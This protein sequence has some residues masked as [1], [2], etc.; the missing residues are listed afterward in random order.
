MSGSNDDGA[1]WIRRFHSSPEAEVRLICFPHAGGSASFFFPVS[2]GLAPRAEVLAMQYPGRQ[3]RRSEPNVPDMTQLAN[4]AADSLVPF[5][6]KPYA[7]FGHSMGSTLAYEVARRLQDAGRPAKALFVSGRRAPHR[8]ADDG[9]HL[10]SDEEI[11]ADIGALDGTGAQVFGDA[12]L[13]DM[14]LPAIRS[15]YQAAETYRYAP[16]PILTSPVHALTGFSDAWVDVSEL[17]HWKEHTEA[18][19]DLTVFPGGHFYLA[20]QHEDILEFVRS[21]LFDSALT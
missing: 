8:N 20:E 6:D 5:T 1:A 2:R 3:D 4:K 7:L 18:G 16:G 21:R 19:F 11:V 10:L 17:H 12:E 14:V 9:L 15:D 13:M